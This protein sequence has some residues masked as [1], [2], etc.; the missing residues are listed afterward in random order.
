MAIGEV[1]KI[2]TEYDIEWSIQN[3]F[4]LSKEC[5]NYYYSPPFSFEGTSW[6]FQI[7]PNG[8]KVSGVVSLYLYRDSANPPIRLEYTFGIK[9]LNGKKD[10]VKYIS[11]VFQKAHQGYGEQSFLLRSNLLERKS[12]LMPADVLTIVCSLKNPKSNG[13]I[14]KSY[15]Y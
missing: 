2:P 12:D 5:N 9:T 11:Y 1:K 4:S 13:D 14:S 6:Y 3:F 15:V 10:S 8:N 7:F